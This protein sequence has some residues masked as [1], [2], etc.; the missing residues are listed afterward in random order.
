M[1]DQQ[2]KNPFIVAGVKRLI[3]PRSVERLSVSINPL[4]RLESWAPAT[5]LRILFLRLA[6]AKIDVQSASF[7][8]TSAASLIGN[9]A[10]VCFRFVFMPGVEIG[11]GAAVAPSHV[12]TKSVPPRCNLTQQW[13][14]CSKGPL[15]RR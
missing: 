15:E 12:A 7:A 11:E 6:G 2:V 4:I 9:R 3:S 8:G 13:P 10:W 1:T 5:W 14:I